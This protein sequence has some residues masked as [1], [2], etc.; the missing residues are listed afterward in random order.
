MQ[1]SGDVNQPTC[2][3]RFMQSE[4]QLLSG[5][6]EV[7]Y[8][9]DFLAE[10]IRNLWTTEIQTMTTLAAIKVAPVTI[11]LSKIA[12]QSRVKSGWIN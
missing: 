10:T 3:F 12:D 2:P 11:S 6:L 5:H 1:L 7:A 8:A 4:G 9:N